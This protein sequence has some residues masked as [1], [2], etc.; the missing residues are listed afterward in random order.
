MTPF[1]SCCPTIAA[2]SL[3]FHAGSGSRVVAGGTAPRIILS[4]IIAAFSLQSY[5]ISG[6]VYS[7][8]NL[9]I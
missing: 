8:S 2:R 1:V 4:N 3:D 7:L 9:L 5:R 6:V